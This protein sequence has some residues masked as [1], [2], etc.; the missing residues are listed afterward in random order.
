MSQQVMHL[1][2]SWLLIVISAKHRM[3]TF[4]VLS[5]AI[6]KLLGSRKIAQEAKNK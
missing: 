3:F 1:K 4:A 2:E 6:V 5:P